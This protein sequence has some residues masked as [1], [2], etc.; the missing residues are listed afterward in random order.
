MQK[1]AISSTQAMIMNVYVHFDNEF[2]VLAFDNQ[3]NANEIHTKTGTGL[4]QNHS[5]VRYS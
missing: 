4:N 1:Y 3:K 2:P 5:L